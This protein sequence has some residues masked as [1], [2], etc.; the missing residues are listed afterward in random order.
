[1]I[2]GTIAKVSGPVVNAEGM[3]GAKMYDITR[4]GDLGL[5]GE[6]V[7]LDGETAIVQVYEDTSGLQVGERVECTEE[8]LL[9]EL[10]PGLLSSIYDG[11]QRRLVDIADE[12]GDFVVRGVTTQP[13]RR[14]R[15]WK[16]EAMVERGD[17]V[18][19][20]D[21]VGEVQE[22]VHITHRIMVPPGMS[23]RVSEVKEGEFNVDQVVVRLE[24][25]GEIKLHQTWPARVPRPV[26]E[27]LNPTVP[28]ITGTRILDTFFPIAQGGYSIIPGGFGTGK[29]VTETTLAKWADADIVIYIGCGERG[30]EITE[31]LAEF[32]SLIDPKTGVPLMQ[33]TILVANTSNMPV[34]ARE[35]SIYTG[36]T[37]AEYYRDMGYNVALMADSTSRWGEALREVSGRLEEMPGEE[38]YPAYLATRLADFYERCG[39]ATCLGSD[40]RPGSITAIGAVSP[41]GGD[42]SEPMTQNS[43]RITG[44]FWALDTSL[45]YRRHFPA[46]SWIKSYTLYLDQIEQWYL[47]NV[48]E[49]W[50]ALRDKAMGLLQKEVELQEIVQLVGPDALPDFAKAVLETTR[51]LREDYLQQ[52]AFSDTDAFCSLRKGYLMLKVILTYYDCLEEA[53]V[54]GVA[55]RQA[56]EHPIKNEIARMKEI[57]SEEAEE[58]ISDLVERVQ[59][60]LRSLSEW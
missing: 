47:K 41:P 34:A 14:D 43:L 11:I 56:T 53:L 30:N 36:I 31:V 32:P 23:G 48:S 46:I 6:V 55:L 8:P 59:S 51:M 12:Y 16:F 54:Q 20:G 18:G 45:A 19:P 22:T 57:S 60:E 35:A 3:A 2:E 4:V 44:A 24:G 52:F 42:F 15:L 33:R 29:T 7:R 39:R 49:D 25:G 58:R 1:M 9:I 37:L 5:I 21:V 50:R 13:L 40:E 26:K 27:K 38:G 28:F 17:E 10:G